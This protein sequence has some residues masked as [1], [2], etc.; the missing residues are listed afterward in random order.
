VFHFAY[1]PNRGV[2]RDERMKAFRYWIERY[3]HLLNEPFNSVLVWSTKV[4]S[5]GKV[6]LV[7]A[8]K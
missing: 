7:P 1:A 8:L 2:V 5:P 3:I 6:P 4:P